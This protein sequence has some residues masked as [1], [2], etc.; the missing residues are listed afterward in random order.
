ME[1][2]AKCYRAVCSFHEKRKKYL[3]SEVSPACLHT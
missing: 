2:K 3:V 1:N